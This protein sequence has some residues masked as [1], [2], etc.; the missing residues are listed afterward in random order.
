MEKKKNLSP[1]KVSWWNILAGFSD[2]ENEQ[3]FIKHYFNRFKVQVQF[4]LLISIFI[5]LAF[6][7]IDINVFPELEAK[8]LINRILVTSIFTIILGFS[9]TKVFARQM[10]WFLLFFGL[11]AATGILWKLR[12]LNYSGYDFS[13]FYPGL[14]LT[15]AIVT[16]YLR[17][18]FVHSALL[19]VFVILA[20]I[21]VFIV[22]IEP[23]PPNSPISVKQTF[24]NS[25]FF[26]FGSGAL[27]LYAAYYLEKMT[28]NNFLAQQHIQYLND[29]LQH[30]V[31]QRTAELTEEKRKNIKLLLDG[32][33]KERK[34]ISKELHDSVG[35]QLAI[36]KM[37]L[38]AQQQAQDFSDLSHSIGA[39]ADLI[40]DVRN[41]SHNHSVFVLQKVGLTKAIENS[42]YQMLPRSQ[43]HFN[44]YLHQLNGSLSAAAQL[45]LFRVF[46][47]ALNNIIKHSEATEVDIQLVRHDQ[48]L[49]LVIYDNGK[50]F[51]VNGRYYG[52]GMHN[53]RMRIENQLEGELIIDSQPGNGTTLIANLKN[54]KL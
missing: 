40:K 36:V 25:L 22:F 15:T 10:Q 43:A 2:H 5:Y 31:Q 21:A 33:E 46:Q 23:I 48:Q 39:V 34:R 54:E 51:N 19:N 41:I 1:T 7:L 13:F 42:L 24:I 11:V 8:L 14:I 53:M 44:V 3:R 52:L 16:F 32:Q 45:M 6:Y 27:S 20:Y 9:F 17:L 29:H 30:E 18:R 28:R 49:S 4:G 38:E 37:N 50:G 47:E 12:L 26:L 35:C